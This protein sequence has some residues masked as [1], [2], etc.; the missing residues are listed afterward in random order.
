MA[1]A[2]REVVV[3][4]PT[5]G[6][7]STEGIARGSAIVGL[8]D[9]GTEE[10]RVYFEGAIY[11]QVNMGTLADR[12]A[13]AYGRLRDDAPTVAARLVP[14]EALVAVGTFDPR[15][16]RILLAGDKSI[17][18]VATWLGTIGLVPAE[19]RPSRQSPAREKGNGGA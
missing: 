18:A 10:V 3:Y 8:P 6:H 5:G 13:H 16:G 15:T 9:P 2:P 14:R 4:V 1:P 7:P 17:A 11:G 12:A 19:L